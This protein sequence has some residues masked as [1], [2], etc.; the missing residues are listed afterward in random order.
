MHRQDILYSWERGGESKRSAELIQ[1][2]MQEDGSGPGPTL[3]IKPRC[4]E[5]ELKSWEVWLSFLLIS[6]VFQQ[7]Q[8]VPAVRA[9]NKV[10]IYH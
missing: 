10:Y 5:S 8:P 4:V 2:E 7:S 9:W 1:K 3:P 6:K